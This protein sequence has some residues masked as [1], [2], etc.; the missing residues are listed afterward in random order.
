MVVRPT[1]RLSETFGSENWALGKVEGVRGSNEATLVSG[2]SRCEA[3]T[4]QRMGMIGATIGG[5][6]EDDRSAEPR[7]AYAVLMLRGKS[8]RFR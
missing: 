3:N 2:H 8:V 7:L 6:N 4:T 1:G 5:Q